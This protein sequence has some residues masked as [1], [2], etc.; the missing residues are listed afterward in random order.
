MHDPALFLLALAYRCVFG[1]VGGYVTARLAP[2][3]PVG[4]ALAL[5]IF[6]LIPSIAGAAATIGNPDLGP[7]WYPIALVISSAPC[8][9]LGGLLRRR[10][11]R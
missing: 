3:A 9:F 2:Y 10:A 11:G 6:G 5:G 7:A 1:I 8:A 4:H